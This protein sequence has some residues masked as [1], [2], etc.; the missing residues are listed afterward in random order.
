MFAENITLNA[1]FFNLKRHDTSIHEGRF[2]EQTDC[3]YGK[4]L[5]YR[6]YR[7][8]LYVKRTYCLFINSFCIDK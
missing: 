8:S 5:S 6:C 1:I 2:Y 7:F 4:Y 3:R